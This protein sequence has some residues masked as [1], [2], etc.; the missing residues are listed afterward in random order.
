MRAS[1]RP[2]IGWI[3]SV[4]NRDH[5]LQRRS[6]DSFKYKRGIDLEKAWRGEELTNSNELVDDDRRDYID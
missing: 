2:S 3:L 4:L 6:E 1:G 5:E